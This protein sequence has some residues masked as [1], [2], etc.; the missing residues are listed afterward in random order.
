MPSLKQV[1]CFDMRGSLQD[2][3]ARVTKWDGMEPKSFCYTSDRAMLIGK[4]GYIGKYNNY[5]DNGSLYRFQ[6]F[7]NHTDL[8]TP[9]VTSILKKLSVIVIG[10]TNQYVTIKWGY[11]FS[12]NYQAQNVLIPDQ[13]VNS[14]YGVSE[15]NVGNYTSGVLQQTLTAYPTGAGI[16]VQTGYESD[17][18]G[19][20]LSIQRIEIAA[21]QGKI[22]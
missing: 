14:Y 21:K 16:V 12:S 7:T 20:P 9:T 11:D 22:T 10:G 4:E 13:G 2:G 5:Q 19:A 15:Y 17:I 8:G 6:Y 1:Y 18:N 3:S